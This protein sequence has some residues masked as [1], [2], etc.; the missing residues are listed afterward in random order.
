MTEMLIKVSGIVALFVLAGI[1]AMTIALKIC[2]LLGL[3]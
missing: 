1:G 3:T 2:K